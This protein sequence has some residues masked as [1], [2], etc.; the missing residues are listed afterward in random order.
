[1]RCKQIVEM[2]E[3]LINQIKHKVDKTIDLEYPKGSGEIIA[4]DIKVTLKMVKSWEGRRD[5]W[6]GVRK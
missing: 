2:Y 4:K 6:I 5:Y 3:T 1:M